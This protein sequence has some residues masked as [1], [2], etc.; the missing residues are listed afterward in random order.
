MEPGCQLG[1]CH[2]GEKNPNGNEAMV[3]RIGGEKPAYPDDEKST[4]NFG[5]EKQ[6]FLLFQQMEQKEK[7]I[8]L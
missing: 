8:R 7:G 6:H 2:H 5:G 1:V 3:V 4:Q